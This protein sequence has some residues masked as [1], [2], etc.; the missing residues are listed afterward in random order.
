MPYCLGY[1]Y[2]VKVRWGFLGL[3]FGVDFSTPFCFDS[4]DPFFFDSLAYL[5]YNRRLIKLQR[6][7][8]FIGQVEVGCW[9]FLYELRTAPVS[10]LPSMIED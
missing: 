7:M 9:L 2:C 4:P 10:H 1:A 5:I 3:I 6:P 8:P